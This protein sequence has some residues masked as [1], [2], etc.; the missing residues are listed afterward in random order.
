MN[1]VAHHKFAS[2][3]SVIAL[4]CGMF[5][6]VIRQASAQTDEDLIEVA[7]SALK[8][9]RQAVVVATM[10]L[11]DA[12]GKDFWPLYREYRNEMDKVNDGLMKLVLE[13][14]KL[15]PSVPDDRAKQM[16]KD[17]TGFQQEQVDKR[18][19]YLKKFTKVLPPAKALRFA[20]VE[21][22]LD[23]LIQLQLAAKVPLV[24]AGD[25]K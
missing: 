1:T 16:L 17:Y 3:I 22:R 23:L 4:T 5:A 6:G 8:T 9:D 19:A 12:E 7:R 25:A 13:Y 15:Y 20:Q 24:P 11:T 18:V 21:T 10:D 14:A 2:A